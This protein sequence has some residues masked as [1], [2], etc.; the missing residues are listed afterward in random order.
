[1]GALASIGEN[2]AKNMK[3]TMKENGDM[4]VENQKKVAMQRRE[5]MMATNIAFAR[6][7][8]KFLSAFTGTVGTLGIIA[9][10]KKRNPAGLIPLLPLSFLLAYQYDMCYGNKMLRV[11]D[12]ANKIL[13]SEWKKGDDN[14]FIPPSNN[15]LITREQYDKFMERIQIIENFN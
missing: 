3:Q 8:F 1:M 6:D 14:M 9:F 13:A 5:M 4:M 7:Q 10:A 11:R 15:L 12:E 2:M